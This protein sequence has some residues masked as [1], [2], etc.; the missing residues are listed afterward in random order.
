V[1][2]M[3][4]LQQASYEGLTAEVFCKVLKGLSGAKVIPLHPCPL[5]YGLGYRCSSSTR[6]T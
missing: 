5:G 4:G 2:M 1:R 6:G 3:G